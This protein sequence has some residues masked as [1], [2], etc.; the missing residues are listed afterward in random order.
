VLVLDGYP[1]YSCLTGD[2]EDIR[3]IVLPQRLGIARARNTGLNESRGRLLA[4][5]DDDCVPAGTWLSALLRMSTKHRKFTALGGRVIGTAP[6]SDQAGPTTHALL[7]AALAADADAGGDPLVPEV[8]PYRAAQLDRAVEWGGRASPP[9][10]MWIGIYN[11][12]SR[13]QPETFEELRMQIAAAPAVRVFQ[14]LVDYVVPDREGSGKV[15]AGDA[16][17]QTWWTLSYYVSRNTVGQPDDTM[18]SRTSPYSTFG[19]GEFIRTDFLE[20]IGGF[21]R[22]AYADGLLLGWVARLAGEP[23]GLLLSRDIAEVPRT[24]EDLVLRQTVWLWGLLNF[25]ITI[26]R[27]RSQGLLNPPKRR[28][29]CCAPATW[30]SP[31]PGG[32]APQR[33]RCESRPNPTG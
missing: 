18:W 13:P 9:P 4:F 6:E 29:S 33:S 3:V 30:R 19:H 24:A 5:L 31:W 7:Q 25:S 20:S 10:Q 11:A 22:Y 28:S 2:D 23:I 17:L 8:C 16:V 1:R 27:R 32:L 12:D 15:A 26:E 21:P 14:Q